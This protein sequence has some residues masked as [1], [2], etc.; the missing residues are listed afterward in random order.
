MRYI[1]K[2]S[3]SEISPASI[4]ELAT[5]FVYSGRYHPPTLT[6]H[7]SFQKLTVSEITTTSIPNLLLNQS[8]FHQPHLPQSQAIPDLLPL[9]TIS[10]PDYTLFP[11]YTHISLFGPIFGSPSD[12][13]VYGFYQL[14]YWCAF[15][16]RSLGTRKDPTSKV[17]KGLSVKLNND[18]FS[19]QKNC[20]HSAFP[21]LAHYITTCANTD[22]T[23]PSPYYEVL[24]EESSKPHIKKA[25]RMQTAKALLDAGIIKPSL[26]K[27][28]SVTG[29][30]KRDEIAKYGKYARIT[31]DL[32]GTR[33]PSL[34]NNVAASLAGLRYLSII[35]DTLCA[36]PLVISNVEGNLMPGYHPSGY[37][38]YIRFISGP[39]SDLM[40]EAFDS[41]LSGSASQTPYDLVFIYYSDDS[42]LSITRDGVTTTWNMDISSCDAS[43]SKHLFSLINDL[44]TPYFIDSLTLQPIIP[45]LIN[46]LLDPMTYSYRAR[47]LNGK[48]VDAY[49]LS[50]EPIDPV[51]YSGSVLT[52][53]V[54]NFG[55]ILIALSIVERR[56]RSDLEITL[57]A[58]EAGYIVTAEHCEIPEDIQFLKHSPTLGISEGVGKYYP[59]LN[60]GPFLRSSGICMGDLPPLHEHKGNYTTQPPS[61]H[62]CKTCHSIPLEA[63]VNHRTQSI[64]QGMYPRSSFMIRDLLSR[65]SSTNET[66]SRFHHNV[67]HLTD[68]HTTR[69]IIKFDDAS[70]L[71]R[72]RQHS[73]DPVFHHSCLNQ[74]SYTGD[75]SP[76]ANAILLKDYGIKAGSATTRLSYP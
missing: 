47:S 44:F 46:Q 41:L 17:Y 6:C 76:L 57:A 59:L 64:I 13:V 7:P 2:M 5:G 61:S 40:E 66:V 67:E 39:R 75:Q 55:N 56:A 62:R 69:S 72:Y 74:L 26:F 36:T 19:R 9:T 38:A 31:F 23:S 45:I 28:G 27:R 33:T 29:N 48:I 12:K 11:D 49:K 53:L 30:L 35:K 8:H 73:I 58:S 4:I 25:L 18:Y 65:S 20:C 14:D 70:I 52:T 68:I 63:Q 43:H 42:S 3:K 22:W 71:A 16:S 37:T 54:N 34:I 15:L 10:N 51:L 21:I 24:I 60:L 1:H 50:Y 32:N